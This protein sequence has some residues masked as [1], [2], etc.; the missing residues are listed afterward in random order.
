MAKSPLKGADAFIVQ[1]RPV[2]RALAYMVISLMSLVNMSMLSSSWSTARFMRNNGAFT[3]VFVVT[4]SVITMLVSGMYAAATVLLIRA[5]IEDQRAPQFARRLAADNVER[6]VCCLMATWWL[7]MALNVSN[8]AFVFRDEIRMCIAHKIPPRVLGKGTSKEAAGLAC[9]VFHGSLALC[10]MI[11]L[12]WVARTWRVFTRS[13]M[14]FDSSIFQE[15]GE[16]SAIDLA[17][18]ANAK[19]QLNPETF[20]PRDPNV[21]QAMQVKHNLDSETESQFTNSPGTAC[22]CADCPMSVKNAQTQRFP[23]PVPRQQNTVKYRVR[24][25]AETAPSPLSQAYPPSDYCCE[26]QPVVGTATL[27]TEPI[28]R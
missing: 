22:F 2:L 15:N 24:P 26:Q 20:S 17:A 8:M 14:H 27:V 21:Y 23:A 10:W 6:M 28:N 4:S 5:R 18:A 16:S 1:R 25:L 13:N 12:M 19:A 3:G 9:T 7:S 11:W